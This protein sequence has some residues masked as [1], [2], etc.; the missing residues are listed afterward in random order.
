M[1]E[2]NNSVRIFNDFVSFRDFVL[3]HNMI[4]YLSLSPTSKFNLT[5]TKKSTK[6]TKQ[7]LFLSRFMHFYRLNETSKLDKTN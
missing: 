3:S 1:E 7:W 5:T 2:T 6:T 4:I